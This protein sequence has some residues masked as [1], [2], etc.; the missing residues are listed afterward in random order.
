MLAAACSRPANIR[1]AV[2]FGT[3]PPD[4]TTITL[5]V[6]NQESRTTS[7]VRIDLSVQL[8]RGDRWGKEA[9]VI[10]PAPTVLNKQEEQILRCTVKL[11]G[12]AIRAVVTIKE[13]RSGRILAKDEYE[14]VLAAGVT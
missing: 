2:D 11:N 4:L 7:P 12:D 10:H 14:K 5:R 13:E 1:T 3:K 9:S 6:K 8:R